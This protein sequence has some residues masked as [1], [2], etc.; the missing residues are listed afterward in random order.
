[1]S[2]LPAIVGWA[3][4]FCYA[5]V[6]ASMHLELSLWLVTPVDSGSWAGLR[7]AQALGPLS[8]VLG[9]SLLLFLALMA[10]HRADRSRT[11][12]FWGLWLGCVVLVDRWI[13]F[14]GIERIHY[15]QYAVLAWLTAWVIDPQRQRWPF[16]AIL[17]FCTLVGIADEIYRI[18]PG[19]YRTTLDR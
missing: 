9:G 10:W 7:P 15:L 14:S 12:L 1:M 18:S 13:L 8:W 5:A 3:A 19:N 2:G 4:V 6:A 16:G 11:L 17:L